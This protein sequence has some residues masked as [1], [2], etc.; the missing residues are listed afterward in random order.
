MA[1]LNLNPAS[2]GL[3]CN[4]SNN[5]N[6]D[7][8]GSCCHVL[9][10]SQQPGIFTCF[11]EK[12]R[13]VLPLASS[14]CT[15]EHDQV[16]L[17]DGKVGSGLCLT[18][19]KVTGPGRAELSQARAHARNP[20][21]ELRSQVEPALLLLHNSRSKFLPS[22]ELA[23]L[24]GAAQDTQ[25]LFSPLLPFRTWR[26]PRIPPKSPLPGTTASTPSPLA[27]DPSLPQAREEL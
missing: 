5:S 23:A 1:H 27:G 7:G 10:T 21:E 14:P 19:R 26:T 15:T 3:L 24:S 16:H 11:M 22:A 2:P 8:G 9:G 12:T 25:A 20:Q 17:L 4:N 13:L 6:G 18:F